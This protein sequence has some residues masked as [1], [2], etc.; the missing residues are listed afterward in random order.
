MNTILKYLGALGGCAA[1]AA[2]FAYAD[3]VRI[4]IDTR[5]SS[6]RHVRSKDGLTF[7][8]RLRPWP[9]EQNAGRG[10][11]ATLISVDATGPSPSIARD[12][13]L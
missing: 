10:V 8:Q 13:P 5:R 3:D 1:L 2:T 6:E 12:R 11:I 9:F 7:L 4:A